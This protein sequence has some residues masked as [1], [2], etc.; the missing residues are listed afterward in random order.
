MPLSQVFFS[1]I[2]RIIIILLF[3]FETSTAQAEIERSVASTSGRSSAISFGLNSEFINGSQVQD[4]SIS[5]YLKYGWNFSSFELGPTLRLNFYDFGFGANTDY[6]AGI[7]FNY[8]F[9]DNNSIHSTIYGL[10][11]QI[12]GGNKSYASDG[13]ALIKQV[14]T[15]LF[16][17][18]FLSQTSLAI[19]TELALVGRQIKANDTEVSAQG[20]TSQIYLIYYY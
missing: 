4:N 14:Q 5:A 2:L 10:L 20:L 19:K 13:R 3:Y 9:N 12:E 17:T 1:K 18:S 8:N 7:Y 6:L 16:L 11:V 15:G